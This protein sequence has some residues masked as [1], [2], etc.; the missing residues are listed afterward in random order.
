M[1]LF[2]TSNLKVYG[3]T[4][5]AKYQRDVENYNRLKNEGWDVVLPPEELIPLSLMSLVN[6]NWGYFKHE[7]ESYPKSDG[8]I[9]FVVFDTGKPRSKYLQDV[10]LDLGKN[11]TTD[12]DVMDNN[13]HSSHCSG[14]IGAFVEGSKIGLMSNNFKIVTEKVLNNQGAGS[15]SWISNGWKHALTYSKDFIKEGWT[16]IWSN[17][18]GGPS[19]WSDSESIL[20]EAKDAGIYIICAAGNSG[21]QGVNYP[22]KSPHTIAIGAT[23]QN[24][25][26]AYFSSLGPEVDFCA[27]G[28][29]IRSCDQ[30]ETGLKLASG[31]SM[32]CPMFAAVCGILQQFQKN[33]LYNL[34]MTYAQ[35]LGEAGFDEYYGWGI[36]KLSRY[37]TEVTPPPPPPKEEKTNIIWWIIGGIVVIIVIFLILRYV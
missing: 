15:G 29:S 24:D 33:E 36:P 4:Q 6:D 20:K 32:A 22:G 27:A 2:S 30:T 14:I 10:L 5:L 16:V 9:L 13:S 18:F 21:D 23:D 1:S 7:V 8:K 28:V 12:P 34:H 11:H 37:P 35:D 31:T 25:Q 26:I 3:F 17:S 19:A